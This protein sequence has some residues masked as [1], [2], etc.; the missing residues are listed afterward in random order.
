ML[1]VKK[2][3]KKYEKFQ[4]CDVSFDLPP[5][6]IMGFIGANGAGKTTT[7]KSLL[8]IVKRDSGEVSFFGKSIDDSEDEIKQFIGFSSGN[9]SFYARKKVR[10]LI[11]VYKRFFTEWSDTAFAEYMHKFHIDID[12]TVSQLSQGM[13]VKLG[14]AMALSHNAK[15]IILDEPTNGLDP[16]ARDELLEIFRSIIADGERSILFSTHITSDL[17]KCA[18][19]ILF[20]KDGKIVEY[21]TKDDLIDSYAIVS[22]KSNE[23]ASIEPRLVGGKQNAFG[24]QGLIKR[25]DLLPTDTVQIAKP[26]IEDIM[27][28]CIKEECK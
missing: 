2:L 11:D 18:D 28:Y 9:V 23:F 17:D 24:F 21:A 22:G 27:F 19:Y 26:N 6:Y 16:I 15:L 20:I 7:I 25:V 12:K 3:C 8:N 13:Q 14:V 10:K 4:L 1:S 5:G